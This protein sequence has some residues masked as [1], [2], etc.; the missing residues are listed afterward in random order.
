MT[1]VGTPA[2]WIGFLAFVLGMLALDLGVFHRRD[3]V[4]GAR[5]ALRW[6]A[7]WITLSLIFGAGVYAW[8]GKA[9]G[10]EFLTAWVV[11]KS[12]SVDN[13][14]VFVVLFGAMGIPREL[15]HRVLFWGILSALVLRAAMILGGTALLA[16][17]HWLA[18]VFGAFLV[19]TGWKLWAGEEQDRTAREKARN[20]PP[21]AVVQAYR[22]VLGDWPEGWPP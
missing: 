13:L 21:P 17:F 14:F 11:E 8:A 16:R 6:S 5:E 9:D 22:D 15:Q 1:T 4:I 3:H 19:Y 7:M 12:L 18:Y 10:Q 20:S 2:L